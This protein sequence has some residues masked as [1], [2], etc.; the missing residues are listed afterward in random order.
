M[1]QQIM[2]Q[3]IMFQQIMFWQIKS[4]SSKLCFSK[5]KFKQFRHRNNIGFSIRKY[6]INRNRMACA[7]YNYVYKNISWAVL[8]VLLGGQ[9]AK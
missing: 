6:L 2:L 1:F 3:Q 7:V 4:S 5:S 9:E 8:K